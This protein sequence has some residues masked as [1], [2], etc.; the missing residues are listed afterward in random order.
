MSDFRLGRIARALR[1][2]L[3]RRQT[4]VARRAGVSQDSVSRVER[5]QVDGV[6]VGT[7]RRILAAVDGDLV[8]TVRWR[9]GE[10][11]RLL[12]EGHAA[13][14]GR[15]AEHLASLGWEVRLEVSFSVY[16]E[17]GS[18]DVLGWRSD[19]RHLIVGE[20]KTEIASVE[21]TLRRHDGKVRLG[22]RIAE[23]RFGWRPRVVGRLLIVPAGSTVRRRVA[24]HGAI[25]SRAYPLRGRELR[26]W[27]QQ[28]VAS[29]GGLLFLSPTHGVRGMGRS[30]PRRRVHRS[31]SSSGTSPGRGPNASRGA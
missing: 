24:R 31:S 19:S 26:S 22:A 14:V 17:R 10:L 8:L 25:F 1:Q 11:D 27:L 29:A 12:D 15:V 16:G 23:D 7:L 21:E 20:V 3:D 28:P 6:T 30:T 13:L 4:D 2:R 9:G 18:I 5:G